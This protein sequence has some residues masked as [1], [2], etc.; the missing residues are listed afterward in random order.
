MPRNCGR[1]TKGVAWAVDPDGLWQ[2]HDFP[3]KKW[4][5]IDQKHDYRYP[6]LTQVFGILI[7]EGWLTRDDLAGLSEEK[8]TEIARI[9]EMR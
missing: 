6:V 9:A 7:G 5:E 3:T 4:K 2:V 1:R 8:M